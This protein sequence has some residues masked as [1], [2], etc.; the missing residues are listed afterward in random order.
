[1]VEFLNFALGIAGGFFIGLT[2]FSGGVSYGIIIDKGYGLYCPDTGDF[3]FTGE[4]E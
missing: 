3:A 1:M 4:C 2:V